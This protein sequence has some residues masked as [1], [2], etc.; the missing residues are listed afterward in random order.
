MDQTSGTLESTP[1]P[2]AQVV[3]KSKVWNRLWRWAIVLTVGLA[4]FIAAGVA[5]RWSQW[6]WWGLALAGIVFMG[7][8]VRTWGSVL[9]PHF[10]YD[11]IRLARR[12]RTRDIRMLYGVALLLGLGLVYWLRFPHQTI[13]ML[14]FDPGR[15]MSINDAARFAE[16]FVFTVIVIQNLTVLLLTPV[17]VGATIA[18]EKERRTLELLFTTH[19]KDREIILGKLFSRILHLGAILLG[20]LPVLS[21]AQLWGGIDFSVLMANFVNTG[22]NLLSVGSVSILVSALCKRVVTAVMIVYGFV[23]PVT[24]C[25]GIFSLTGQTSVLGL[26]Q[27]DVAA[28]PGVLGGVMVGFFTFHALI[29]I[30]CISVA[31]VVLRGQRTAEEIL[32]PIPVGPIPRPR[33]RRRESPA[34]ARVVVEEERPLTLR[35]ERV[36]DLPPVHND[37]LYWKELNLGKNSALYGPLFYTGLGLSALW[38]LLGFFVLLMIPDRKPWLERSHELGILVKVVAIGWALICCIA[39]AFFATAGIVRERQQGTLDAL[40]TLP[41]ARVEILRGKWLGSFFRGWNWWICFASVPLLGMLVTALHI[42]GGLWF[43]AAVAIHGAFFASLG[44]FYSVT[45]KTTIASY[46]KMALTLMFLLFG[47][48]LVE[49]FGVRPDDPSGQFLRLGLNPVRTWWTLGFSYLDYRTW[50]RLDGEVGGALAG[51]TF[52]GALAIVFWLLSMWR[53]SRERSWKT[54]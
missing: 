15:R 42:S 6:F 8:T 35:R 34:V 29:S 48:W 13:D 16:V 12:S 45:S 10:F 44:L 3:A 49:T 9:G 54:E 41:I 46:A 14:L 37:P 30:A 51:V 32:A 33:R 2:L 4:T 23:L 18:E 25:L 38:L 11:L 27:S 43:A 20:G 36:Y 50:T 1:L 24:F 5:S 17:F 31:F 47:T 7:L 40:L 21:L 22:L 26:A 19:L 39:T 53:F 52:F 28:S